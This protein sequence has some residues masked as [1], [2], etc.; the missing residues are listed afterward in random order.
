MVTIS[1]PEC[2]EFLLLKRSSRGAFL[3]CRNYPD[4]DDIRIKEEYRDLENEELQDLDES[5]LD[6]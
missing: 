2:D 3:R 1:C 4:C 6:Y 5:M